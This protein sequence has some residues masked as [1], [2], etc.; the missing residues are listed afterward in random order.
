MK[1]ILALAVVIA[2]TVGQVVLTGLWPGVA[3]FFDLP[4]LVVIYCGITRGPAGAL[5]VGTS[6]GL[7][8]DSLEGTLLGVSALSQ[9]LVGYL[10]GILGLRFALAPLMSRILVI[11]A[12][13][14]LG[15]SIEVGTLA[16]MGRKLSY[17][18]FPALLGNVLGNCLLGAPIMGALRRES[19]Q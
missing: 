3:R 7:L 12:A 1:F 9:A 17:S 13:T 4:L 10:V 2:S 8:Q 18:P 19:P 5:L 15:S 11:A 16:I 6:A 14:V